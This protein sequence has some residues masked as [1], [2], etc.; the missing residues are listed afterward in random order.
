M[1]PQLLGPNGLIYCVED[2]NQN[3]HIL[4]GGR[5]YYTFQHKDIFTKNLGIALLADLHVLQNTICEIFG[6]NRRTVSRIHKLYKKEG[7]SGLNDYRKG[8][9]RVEKFLKD[10]IITK[11]LEL[12]NTRGYQKI[13]L[14]EVKQKAKEGLFARSI[15][16]SNMQK[17]ILMHKRK[18]KAQQEFEKEEALRKE[19]DK[20]SREKKKKAKQQSREAAERLQ[21]ELFESEEKDCVQH[22]GAAAVIP[23]LTE[24][25]LQEF[26]PDNSEEK[27]LF[28]NSEMTV[29]YTTLNAASLVEV[30]QDFKL[31]ARYQM[32]GI[33][34][35]VK[36][37]SLSLYRERIP[38]IV[39]Q[40][41]MS[42]V[43]VDAAKK[44]H[45]L[46]GFTKVVYIDGHFMPYYGKSAILY[47][48][49]SQ[50]RL[51]MHGREYFFVHD[52]SG[53]P[54]YAAISDGYRKMKHYIEKVDGKLREIYGVGDKELLEIFDRGGY[55]KK[56]CVGIADRI[57]FICWRSDAAA[58]PAITESEWVD[59]SVPL[60][61][62][63]YG[64]VKVKKLKAWER[65][66]EFESEGKKV[67]F[68]EIWIRSG[69]K[70]SP[71]LTNEFKLQLTDV[72]VTLTSRWGKQENMFK[73]LK[74]H[75]IDR[76]HSY[77]KEFYTEE[78]L[79]RKGLEDKEQGVCH[80]INN[81]KIRKIKK[82]ISG[83]R[84]EKVKL[85]AKIEKLKSKRKEKEK[86][87]LKRKYAGIKRKIENRIKKC[88]QL[89]KKVRMLD[90]IE[91]EKIVRLADGKKL[92]FDWLKM[93]SI[94]AKRK[95]I[96][97]VKPIYKDLRDVNRFVRSILRSRTYVC[98]K[99][100][101]LQ[102]SFPPQSSGKAEKALE[103]LCEYLN[104]RKEINLNLN[105]EK[106]HFMVGSKH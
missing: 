101:A 39:T 96:E 86:K 51:A 36:L 55:S 9:Y 34:G 41:D 52:A 28:N 64:D 7:I 44:A 16:R 37:P 76:I 77:R 59:V 56:F 71:A 4:W 25:G 54:V 30:E 38:Q 73:E 11:Y 35:R 42:Q 48:Y 103:I 80:E 79:Y 58:I 69:K 20:E 23:F 91:E 1:V 74:E 72:V 2:E 62:N 105:F 26:L 3:V 18:M 22:G 46:F 5:K 67:K 88:E 92:F 53:L 97:I 24:F 49:C 81:P 89:P 93:N 60:Q 78:F 19:K 15:S 106:I 63:E 17:I 90:R 66:R 75:G 104:D 21:S 47:G 84:H 95:I 12:G 14:E 31:L 40:M 29:S 33:I 102:V 57:N 82:E 83:L 98:R 85:A 43:M 68:R 65:K 87:A 27:K 99:G 13:I 8:R 45:K 94:W 61:P 32:G 100:N 70:I 6:V 50:R 10:F